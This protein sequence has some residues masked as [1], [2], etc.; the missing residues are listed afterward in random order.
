MIERQERE[1]HLT[2]TG[3]PRPHPEAA[4]APSEL[5]TDVVM[6]TAPTKDKSAE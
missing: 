1:G 3:K 2:F 5:R 4:P 6:P